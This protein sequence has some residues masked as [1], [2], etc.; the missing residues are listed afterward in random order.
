MSCLFLGFSSDWSML[1][2]NENLMSAVVFGVEQF[3]SLL[4]HVLSFIHMQSSNEQMHSDR[5]HSIGQ[6]FFISDPLCFAVQ[7]Y[8]H[9]WRGGWKWK[10]PWP[11]VQKER[12]YCSS[13]RATPRVDEVIVCLHCVSSHPALE[14]QRAGIYAHGHTWRQ[15]VHAAKWEKEM[16]ILLAMTTRSTHVSHSG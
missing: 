13:T 5:S 15:N 8:M 6:D 3:T 14:L 9:G 7:P 16:F 2:R 11:R 10:V 1:I 4:F 12:R